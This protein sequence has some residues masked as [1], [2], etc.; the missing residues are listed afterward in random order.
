MDKKNVMIC[1]GIEHGDYV[2]C[3]NCGA[4]MLVPC[5]VD[6]CPMCH[7]DGCL[8]WADDEQ[9]HKFQK[10]QIYGNNKNF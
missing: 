3:S 2:V 9:E 5:G 8:M 6:I 10:I 1:D 4:V 7:E